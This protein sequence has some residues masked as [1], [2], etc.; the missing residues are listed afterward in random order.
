MK[1]ANKL[2]ELRKQNELTQQE[3]AEKLNVTRQ[4]IISIE[5]GTYTPSLLLALKIA[6]YFN[7]KVE[8]IFSYE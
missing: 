5:K 6:K 2:H 3:L 8:E 1:V 4:T 7:S